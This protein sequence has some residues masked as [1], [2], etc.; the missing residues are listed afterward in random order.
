M[1]RNTSFS[2]TDTIDIAGQSPEAAFDRAINDLLAVA[3]RSADA[4]VARGHEIDRILVE[5]R[6]LRAGPLL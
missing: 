2:L 6:T 1:R 4:A 3:Q 5:I